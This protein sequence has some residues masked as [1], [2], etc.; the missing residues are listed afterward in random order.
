M[1]SQTISTNSEP[2]VMIKIPPTPFSSA[3]SCSCL[4]FQCPPATSAPLHIQTHCSVSRTFSAFHSSLSEPPLYSWPSGQPHEPDRTSSSSF[5][6][7]P[8][9][10]EEMVLQRKACL[11][12]T[13]QEDFQHSLSALL[14][15][16][17]STDILFFCILCVF[18]GN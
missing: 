5:L 4:S 13:R 14:S 18:F 17:Y 6:G 1:I 7:S 12:V 3:T 9:L 2:V 8:P 11:R 16:P 10:S 15:L